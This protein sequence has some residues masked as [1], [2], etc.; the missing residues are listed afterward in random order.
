MRFRIPA[1]YK[2]VIIAIIALGLA[3]GVYVAVDVFG[4]PA[5]TCCAPEA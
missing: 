2:P 5:V 3:F 4:E 1:G